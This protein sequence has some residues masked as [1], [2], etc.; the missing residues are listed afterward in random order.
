MASTVNSGQQVHVIA[1]TH[2]LNS[3]VIVGKRWSFLVLFILRLVLGLPALS[4]VMPSEITVVIFPSLSATV[5]S[6]STQLLPTTPLVL[7]LKA[8]PQS[9]MSMPSRTTA[10][11]GRISSLRVV[12]SPMTVWFRLALTHWCRPESPRWRA[13]SYPPAQD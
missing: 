7:S 4:V 8:S 3:T 6:W 13:F 12:I 1:N 10:Y 11:C 2:F 5:Y 9:A